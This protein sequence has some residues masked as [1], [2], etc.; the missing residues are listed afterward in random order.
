MIISIK[1]LS[2][3]CFILFYLQSS[4][5]N[6][7]IT[8]YVKD[9]TSDE[10]LIG[11]TILNL[12]KN[13]GVITDNYGFFS[14]STKK[15]KIKIR[16]SYI[17][18]Q[19]DTLDFV[20][21]R[22]TNLVFLLRPTTL[23]EV[24]VR[25]DRIPADQRIGVVNIPIEQ[26]KSRPAL[27]GEADIMK[28]LTLTPG[29][30]AGTEGSSGL[31]VRGGTPDQ[32]HV[33]LDGATVYNTSHL[34]GFL[35][36][37]NPDAVKSVSLYK[38]DIPA[39]FG[40]R[41]SSIVDVTM[42]E[43]NKQERH[44]DF[45][46]GLISSHF[47][48]EGPIKKGKSSY[49]FAARSSY[50]GALALP[51][52]PGFNSKKRNDY[53]NYWMYD[54]NGKVNF[55]LG[56]KS[57][58]Y[59]SFYSGKDDWIALS[60]ES[61]QRY[62]FGLNWGNKTASLRYTKLLKDKVFVN[63][64]LSYNRYR[65]ALENTFYEEDDAK[66]KDYFANRSYVQDFTWRNSLKYAVGK[67]QLEGGVELNMQILQPQAVEFQGGNI[68]DDSIRF[69]ESQKYRGVTTAIYVEDKIDLTENLKSSIGIRAVNFHTQGNNYSFLEPRLNLTY[70]F[71]NETAMQLSWRRTN[72]FLH[73][74]A[75]SSIGLPN[76]IWVPATDKVPPSTAHQTSLG[77]TTTIKS[78]NTT[79][80]IEAYYKEMRN[81]TDYR[82]G[83][84]IVSSGKSWEQ[85]IETKGQGQAY[86]FEG[87]LHRSE[88]RFNGWLAYTLAWN[89]RQFAN[90]NQGKWYPHRFDR[91]HDI[92]VTG[93]F[94]KSEKWSFAANFVFST[95]DAFTA[96]DYFANINPESPNASI[97]PIYTEKNSYRTPNYHRLDLSATKSYE[98]KRGHNASWSFGVYNAYAHINP[99]YID[100]KPLTLGTTNVTQGVVKY[101]VKSLFTFIPSINYAIKF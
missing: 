28:A 101:E 50:Y 61:G 92:A 32:N 38:G 26:L 58:L 83:I 16:V 43:G 96:P 86:G 59:F 91:R 55:D 56:K 77:W 64:Q 45:S 81:L 2:I 9:S 93:S 49:L 34:F 76:E 89:N 25:G 88:G 62:D 6:I 71:S 31:Y 10:Y 48:T 15:G 67:H 100:I 37:F 84:N 80:T 13:Q 12:Q 19:A 11:A 17:G 7:S 65:F 68:L 27:L 35:S 4:A 52:K 57:H 47:N 98:T 8:G 90:I 78:W 42:K 1:N 97:E 82:Q 75:T 39:R 87:M 24:L 69:V 40:S 79:A 60:R 5:Q 14:I 22:D 66:N 33:L 99:F 94:K 95:G 72:Q 73:L 21:M 51:L 53:F 54:L 30:R 74:L 46:L 23:Q 36:V 3:L 85:L 29:V 41:L 20:A 70:S 63:S 18:Y 44:S